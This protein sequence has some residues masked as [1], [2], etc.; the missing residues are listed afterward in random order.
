MMRDHVHRH[1]LHNAHT[2][3]ATSLS[4]FHDAAISDTLSSADIVVEPV[5]HT[6]THARARLAH[7]RARLCS[8]AFTLSAITRRC[9]A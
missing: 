2:C 7:T 1:T 5:T 9:A 6:H 8:P 3:L 4:A